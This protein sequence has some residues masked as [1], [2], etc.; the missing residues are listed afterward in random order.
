MTTNV[1]RL[2]WD[3]LPK[4]VVIRYPSAVCLIAPH[5]AERAGT[6]AGFEIF[7]FC[8]WRWLRRVF[9]YAPPAMASSGKA[10][11][12]AANGLILLVAHPQ[13]EPNE[14]QP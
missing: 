8:W 12:R 1:T 3:G 4:S 11:F 7:G 9:S 2:A 14:Q 5:G 10:S 13:L 6:V